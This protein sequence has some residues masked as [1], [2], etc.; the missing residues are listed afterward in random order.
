MIVWPTKIRNK[1]N[2]GSKKTLNSS[3]SFGQA[4]LQHFAR[5]EADFLLVFNNK[6]FSWK[7]TCLDPCWLGKWALCVTAQQENLVASDYRT[8]LF[9][10]PENKR[11]NV[12]IIIIIVSPI[13]IISFKRKIYIY[14][15]ILYF[16][17]YFL[18]VCSRYTAVSSQDPHLILTTFL[19]VLLFESAF[20]MDVHIFYKMFWQ[21]VILAVFGLA[22]AT[23]LSGVMAK[24]VF[25]D[26]GWTWFEALLFGSIVSATDP[27]AVVA[28]L[29]DLGR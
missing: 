2:Q 22:V 26:Y 7:M 24:M 15:L 5:P 6:W 13:D 21:V 11:I 16:Y 17:T 9:S 1:Q 20:A 28:L 23:A 29:N 27:V 8:G 10:S 18:L 3:L 4:A 19:P 12:F 14:V 25:V